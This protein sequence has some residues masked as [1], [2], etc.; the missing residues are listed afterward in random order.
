M[1]PEAVKYLPK[2]VLKEEDLHYLPEDFT[3]AILRQTPQATRQGTTRSPISARRT[4]L[5]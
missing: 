4:I 5:Y 1:G 3:C 2:G